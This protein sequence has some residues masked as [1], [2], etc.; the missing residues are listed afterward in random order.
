MIYF[1]E[2]AD[3]RIKFGFLRSV[4]AAGPEIHGGRLIA[5][6]DGN[7]HRLGAIRRMF[8]GVPHADGWYLPASS[9]FNFIKA[10]AI[11]NSPDPELQTLWREIIDPEFRNRIDNNTRSTF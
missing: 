2:R 9:L 11:E 6:V 4:Y 10:N 8:E 1:V 7:S 5:L 3:G